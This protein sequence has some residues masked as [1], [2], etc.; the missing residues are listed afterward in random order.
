MQSLY[1]RSI[2]GK[3]LINSVRSSSELGDAVRGGGMSRPR[4]S[5]KMHTDVTLLEIR[6]TSIQFNVT[7]ASTVLVYLGAVLAA[8]FLA[9]LPSPLISAQATFPVG[10]ARCDTLLH[11][12]RQRSETM[13]RSRP[14]HRHYRLGVR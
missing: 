9:L 4:G 13:P 12:Q 11:R 6:I 1:L 8:H 14:P 5:F 3:L 7:P 2:A 10:R